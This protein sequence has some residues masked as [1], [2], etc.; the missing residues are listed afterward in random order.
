VAL[1]VRSGSSTYRAWF[2]AELTDGN[3]AILYIPEGCAHGFVTLTD[4]A[5]VAYQ[6][7]APYA[8][9]AARGVRWDD[10]AFDIDWPGEV[11]VI[12]RRDASY[13][14]VAP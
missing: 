14:D 7:S 6:A 10:P 5:E 3:R 1:D 4:A 9:D 2:G 13:P 12:N 8:S 11:L